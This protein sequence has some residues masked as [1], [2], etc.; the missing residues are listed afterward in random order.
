GDLRGARYDPETQLIG[1]SVSMV[2]GIRRESIGT[3]Q[4]AV[5]AAGMLI[6][7]PGGNAGIGNLVD[8]GPDGV[9]KP[10]PIPPG[11]YTRWDLSRDRH[12]MAAV[13]QASGYQELRVFDLRDVQ[14]FSWLRSEFVGQPLWSPDGT[15]LLVSLQDSTGAKLVRGSPFISTAPEILAT[16]KVASEMP[17]PLD[18]HSATV[19]VAGTSVGGPLLT[20]DPTRR[21]VRFDTIPGV[22]GGFVMMSPNSQHL[23]FSRSKGSRVMVT[24]S[25]PGGTERQIAANAVEPLW[26]S[27]AEVLYRAGVT[28]HLARLDPRT[29]EPV[30]TAT[31]WGSDPRFSDTFGWSNRPDWT[32]GIV[33]QQG[34]PGTNARYLRVIPNWGA[35]MKAVVDG[36]K[37]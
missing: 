22:V 1:R 26:L 35:Q 37:Q 21:P 33:Y 20:F 27:D 7:A 30:G 31:V 12:W 6:Y 14:S 36:A 34:P 9:V 3:A 2:T 4:Y 15:S 11:S 10:L 25:A 13:V 5:N 24:A 28:W 16:T 29:G 17:A 32:G 19:V 23:L 18:Y 8:L